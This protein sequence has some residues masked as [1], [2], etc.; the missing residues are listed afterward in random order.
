MG[1][2][3]RSPDGG[4]TNAVRSLV[5][6]L[7][8]ASPPPPSYGAHTHALAPPFAPFSLGQQRGGHPAREHRHA[9]RGA[10]PRAHGSAQATRRLAGCVRGDAG[11]ACVAT[12]A[13]NVQRHGGLHVRAGPDVEQ[14]RTIPQASR[15]T[16]SPHPRPHFPATHP[17]CPP[18]PPPP[19]PPRP[20]RAACAPKPFLAT[21]LPC[22][23]RP[24]QPTEGY[25]IA[26]YL[27]GA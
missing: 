10:T 21:A 25:S 3:T 17:P 15:S 24:A 19:F 16:I 23:P 14:H 18:P 1:R 20:T 27:S 12:R 9:R 4:S 26:A 7:H 8:R 2:Y 6:S 13:A 11:G 22:F 5:R